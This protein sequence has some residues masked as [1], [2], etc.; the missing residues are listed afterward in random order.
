MA[1]LKFEI[2]E[3]FGVLSTSKSGWQTEL[4]FVQW[5]DGT[6][7]FDLRSWSPEHKKMGKGITLTHDDIV[8][9]TEVLQGIMAQEA[10][11]KVTPTFE[12][13]VEEIDEDEEYGKL[14]R[15]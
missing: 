6:P 8:K 7:K 12:E 14:T 2:L 1:D 11:G 4:N 9:L 15:F 10:P 5:G 13:P 3:Q